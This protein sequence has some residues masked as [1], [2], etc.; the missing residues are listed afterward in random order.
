MGRFSDSGILSDG[1]FGQKLKDGELMLPHEEPL[2]LGRVPMPYV[3]V[4]DAAFP[5]MVNLMRLYLETRS[6]TEFKRIFNYRLCRARRVVENAFGILAS[7]F[8]VF[9]RP[10]ECRVDLVDKVVKAACVLHN[11]L[12]K[13]NYYDMQDEE[14][15]PFNA[16]Q[17]TPLIHFGFLS[18]KNCAHITTYMQSFR[19]KGRVSKISYEQPDCY[20]FGI[21]FK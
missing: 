8:R 18:E 4:G 1:V 14:I 7:R 16:N 2:Y 15:E 9:R 17:L 12:I 11:Y 3:F 19:G 21:T 20:N 5:L 10:F 13:F 6:T